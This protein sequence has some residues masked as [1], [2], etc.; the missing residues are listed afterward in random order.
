M[1]DE[2]TTYTEWRTISVLIGVTSPFFRHTK[3]LVMTEFSLPCPGFSPSATPVSIQFLMYLVIVLDLFYFVKPFGLPPSRRFTWL[4]PNRMVHQ[5][6]LVT[7]RGSSFEN[8]AFQ[9]T[10]DLSFL[11]DLYSLD[12]LYFSTL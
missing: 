10:R 9:A 3:R 7:A 12:F 11:R 5:R 2:L 1:S 6:L 8:W 4:Q